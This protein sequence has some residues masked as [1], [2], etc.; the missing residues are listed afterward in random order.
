MKILLTALV[1]LFSAACYSQ[2]YYKDIIGTNETSQLIHTYKQNKVSRVAIRSFNESNV[3]IEDFSVEQVFDGRNLRTITS[4][5]YTAESVLVSFVDDKNRVVKTIDSNSRLFTTTTYQYNEAGLLTRISSTS[6]DSAKKAI[7]SEEHIWQYNQTRPSRLL[8]IKNGKD[9]SYIELKL[10]EKGNIIEEQETRRGIKSEPIF[11]YYN[12]NNQLTD[13]VQYNKKA[14]RL[15]PE[16]LFEYSPSGQVIQRITVPA[17]S[18]KYLIWRY[19]YNEKGLKTKEVV[20]NKQK[21]LAGKVEYQYSF[22]Q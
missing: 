2:H 16:Y 10:D 20:Y 11:Y 21:Q 12:D 4:S 3:R 19:Q 22:S 18:D 17:G 13:I 15:L 8:R 1:S 14:R 5:G 7:Q 6:T 9:T